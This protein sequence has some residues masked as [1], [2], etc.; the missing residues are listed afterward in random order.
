MTLAED[1]SEAKV[2]GLGLSIIVLNIG[3]YFVVPAMII[4]RLKK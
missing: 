2:L 4:H 3:M 1:G